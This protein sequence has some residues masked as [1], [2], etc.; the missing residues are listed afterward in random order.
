M[1]EASSE[2]SVESIMSSDTYCSEYE[3]REQMR[4]I[5]EGTRR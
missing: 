3:R 2:K 5:V 4:D 1:R